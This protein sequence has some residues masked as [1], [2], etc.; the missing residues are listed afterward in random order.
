MNKTNK[1]FI[2]LCIPLLAILVIFSS[3]EDPGSVGNN[4]VDDPEVVYDTLALDNISTVNFNGY[5]GRFPYITIG[6]FSDPIFGEVTGTGMVKPSVNF[7]IPDSL[8]IDGNNFNMKLKLQVD[9][10][11]TFGDTLSAPTFS[12]YD[13]TSNWR[14][15]SQRTNTG[16]TYNESEEVG[17]F[18]IQPGQDSLIVNLSEGWKDSFAEVY[19]NTAE[20]AD[21]V[22]QYEFGGLAIVPTGGSS[23]IN[24]LNASNT[25]FLVITTDGADTLTV[26]LRDWAFDIE[27]NA[28][29]KP[30]GTTAIHSTIEE[31]MK[32][33]FPISEI[34]DRYKGVNVLKAEI[35][36]N[37]AASELSSSLGANEIRPSLNFLNF[38]LSVETQQAYDYQLLEPD[39][40]A[41][42]PSGE[43]FYR[44]N[45]TNYFNNVMFGGETRNELFIG[46][47]SST[48]ILRST[49]IYN[50]SAPDNVKPKLIITSI[51]D[52]E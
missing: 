23:R 52:E 39:F 22:Y 38:S 24:F 17:N 28:A 47:G 33:T 36:F 46:A 9:S 31:M 48:G 12:L 37:Q 30:A 32:L 2:S 19:N 35:I 7:N 5:T 3:C 8:G 49:L 40:V 43:A 16:V 45:V 51:S 34:K 10:I 27:R 29:S 18:T 21:S 26:N 41:A 15:N 42:K 4:F 13:I 6:T 20:N 14:G 11:S 50:N 25:Q 1:G 44:S